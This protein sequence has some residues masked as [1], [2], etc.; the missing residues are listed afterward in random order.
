V[1]VCAFVRGV[2]VSLSVFMCVHVCCVC[3]CVFVC[4]VCVLMCVLC[5]C[6]QG[7]HMCLR[8]FFHAMFMCAYVC[9]CCACLFICVSVYACYMCVCILCVDVVYMCVCMYVCACVHLCVWCVCVCMVCVYM[10][11]GVLCRAQRTT[12]EK[13]TIFSFQGFFLNKMFLSYC[14]VV[15]MF[16]EECVESLGLELQT[17]ISGCLCAGVRPLVLCWS[18]ALTLRGASAGSLLDVSYMAALE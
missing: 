9:L 17:V 1:S 3:S 2:C 15:L 16:P 14:F 4:I 11:L 7:M 6:V 12:S 5:V 13:L 10:I 8:V 18:R